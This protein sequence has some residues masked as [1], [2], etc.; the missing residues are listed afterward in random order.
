MKVRQKK[1]DGHNDPRVNNFTKRDEVPSGKKNNS[2]ALNNLEKYTFF[3]N[4]L[5][6]MFPT[7]FNNILRDG[8][9]QVYGLL[10]DKFAPVFTDLFYFLKLHT[11]FQFKFLLDIVCID[12]LRKS[13]F[14]LVYHLLSPRYGIRLNVC[15]NVDSSCFVESL[16]YA[17]ASS[18][19]LEREIWDMFGVF[20]LGHQDLRRILTDYGFESFPLRK[21][22]PVVG[23][24][25]IF[26]SEA[27]K[28]ILFEPVELTQGF[29]VFEIKTSWS[30]DTI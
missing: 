23:Y 6:T 8:D 13:R 15:L 7:F 21:D 14:H 10:H 1:F 17:Y 4:Y 20:F 22:F 24:V 26:Y 12:Y 2:L 27:Q 18:N 16:Y 29:R 30:T 9:D 28:R 11:H 5:A 3:V 25:E 19:W